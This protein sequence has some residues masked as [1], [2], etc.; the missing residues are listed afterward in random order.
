MEKWLK[1]QN[2]QVLPKSSIGKAIA[3]SLKLWTKLKS[4]TLDGRYQIDNNLIEN[5]IRP[6]AVGRKT[7][8][9]QDLIIS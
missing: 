1:S 8:C 2:L 7:I 4:Y 6:L 5:T 3:Y 9:F